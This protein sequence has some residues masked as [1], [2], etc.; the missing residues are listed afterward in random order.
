[1]L[2]IR[3]E[4]PPRV[5]DTVAMLLFPRTGP[6]PCTRIPNHSPAEVP[7][8]TGCLRHDGSRPLYLA[9]STHVRILRRRHGMCELDRRRPG[10][11]IPRRDTCAIDRGDSTVHGDDHRRGFHNALCSCRLGDGVTPAGDH[12]SAVQ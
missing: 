11:G 3:S 1:M 10:R 9:S 2:A 12:S 5:M 6:D 7:N 4:I 8:S